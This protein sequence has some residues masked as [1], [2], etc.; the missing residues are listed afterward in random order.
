MPGTFTYTKPTN[1]V[2]VTGGTSG[3]PADFASFVATDRAGSVTLL[4]AWTPNSNTKTL[5]Y[6]ITPV[7]LL[8]LLI[9]FV[10][11]SKTTETDYIFITGTDAWGNAQ[12]ES[13]NVSAGNGTYVSTKRFRTI[14]NIDCSDNAA[15]GGTVWANGTVAV[16]QPQWGV[17]WNKGNGQYQ[18]D[19]NFNVGNE[20]TSTY[21]MSIKEQLYGSV[22]VSISVKANATLQI[23]KLMGSYGYSGSAWNIVQGVNATHFLMGGTCLIYGSIIHIREGAN[24]LVFETGVVTVKNSIMSSNVSDGGSNPSCSN[25]AFSSLMENISLDNVWFIDTYGPIIQISPILFNDIRFHNTPLGLLIQV[26]MVIDKPFLMT[27]SGMYFIL[28]TDWGGLTVTI[29]DCNVALTGKVYHGGS[30]A[31]ITTTKENFR[32]NVHVVDST[33][34]NLSDAVVLC[35]DKNNDTVFS[36]S[37]DANGNITEQVIEY[38]RFYGNTYFG[39]PVET[40]YSPHKFTISKADYQTLVLENITVD[41]PIVWHLELQEPGV[42]AGSALFDVNGNPYIFLSNPMILKV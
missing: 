7:E 1:I 29:K 35:R 8:A 3:S 32:C 28:Y 37:T 2:V 39:M 42:S 23:G 20:S 12:T 24:A 26:S 13:I 16:T 40:I 9:S 10:V 21:F 22:G 36:V 31:P 41:H 4:A 34:V 38:R 15:G 25:F 11:A 27:V 33:G 14:T 30:D 6:Q 5:T 17:I 19:S 18:N